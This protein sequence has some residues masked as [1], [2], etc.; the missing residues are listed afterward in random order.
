MA[1]DKLVDST[2]LDAGLTTVANAIRT[3]GGITGSLAFPAGFAAAIAAIPS[4][5]G[6]DIDTLVENTIQDYSSSD[7][8]TIGPY[9]FYACVNLISVDCPNVTKLISGYAFSGCTKLKSINLHNVQQIS[10]G[11]QY[12]FR[13]CKSLV[14]AALPLLNDVNS[15]TFSGCSALQ[16]VDVKGAYIRNVAFQ[17]CTVFDT[18]ILR[19]TSVSSLAN[20]NAFNGTP[21]ASGGSGGTL[22][23]PQSLLASAYPNATNW[24]TILGYAN[25]QILPIEGSIYETQYADGTPIT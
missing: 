18:L 22:Y 2:Q 16:K 1:V 25:N 10:S 4:G 6:G 8:T 14:N 24:S 3:K 5:G 11:G 13:D 7:I 9:K 12:A 17:N 20:I 19:H 21:F 23:V 15:N